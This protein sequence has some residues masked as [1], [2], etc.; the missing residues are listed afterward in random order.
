VT[1]YAL[2]VDLG[3]TFSAAA[4]GRGAT[5]EPLSLGTEA[6][7]V[8]SVVLIRD[9]GEILV[10]D[11]AERRSGLEPINTAR[12]FKRRLGDPV[13]LV[14]GGVTHSVES[15]MAHV[16]RWIVERATEREGE[17]PA[18]VVLTH[19]ANYFGYKIGALREV[20]R[21]AGLDADHVVLL[22][23]PEAA[24]ISY[25]REQRVESGEV[26]AVYDFGG[27]TFDAALVRRTDDH[28]E[29]LGVP[30]GM[31][32]LGGIDFD[33]AVMAH[34]DDALGGQVSAANPDDPQTWAGLARLRVECR[35]AKEALS[36]DTDTVVPVALP[37]LQMDVALTRHDLEAMVRPRIS[38]TTHALTRVV[39]SAGIGMD[40][41]TR[42]LLVG[43][44]SRMPIVAESV[45]RS[46]GRPV[47][48][49]AHPK[50][51]IAVG[52]ALAGAASLAPA[53]GSDAPVWHPPAPATHSTEFRAHPTSNGGGANRGRK[54][55]LIIAAVGGAIG[56]AAVV[57][58]LVLRG[59]SSSDSTAPQAT[60]ESSAV[61]ASVTTSA[62]SGVTTVPSAAA[63]RGVDA[64]VTRV[65]FGTTPAG[66][67]IPGPPLE[68]GVAGIDALAV[69]AQGDVFVATPDGAVL[70]ISADTV[71]VVGQLDQADGAPGGI[72]VTSDGSV[73]VSTSAGVLAIG[74]GGS[75]L[76]VDA[77]AAGLGS[78]PGPLAIDGGGNLYISDNGTHRIVR[79][80]TDGTLSLVAGTG[81]AAASGPP[82]GDGQKAPTVALGNV[83]G[84][85]ID[86]TGN[87]FV[88]DDGVLAV[89][90]I[91]PDGTVSTLAGG[92][93]AP[94][95][96][97]AGGFVA[98]GTSAADVAFGSIDG[99]AVDGEGR[100]YVAD[101]TSGAIVRIDPDGRL[102]MVITRNAENGAVDGVPARE[103]S[104]DAVGSLVVDR[105]GAL[106]FE[107]GVALRRIDGL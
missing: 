82:T 68:A 11:A 12:E 23:E 3:T 106:S 95:G 67:G 28:F 48:L 55:G 64:V 9:N 31:E 94:L 91:A 61:P 72:A 18:V 78:T 99:I 98:D 13:P 58:A 20:A 102:A 41:V 24:A 105:F 75:T 73:L 88:A 30:E 100:V 1:A 87:I 69:D 15:L 101:A 107:D 59:G 35:R 29:L 77:A 50:L 39:A 80:Q 42:V 34:V 57:A 40:Q 83:T 53:D 14:I 22:T 86:A 21:L 17:A 54:R 89:R 27:G 79:R 45:M 103:S 33:Q 76:L 37:G 70:R 84:L 7:Q 32:R 47:G 97:G 43:G 66:S 26:V 51:A 2:G 81:V 46:T 5:A 85:A 60:T 96:D 8:P 62:T 93:A 6:A 25:A 38:E 52:A 10:G 71:E 90:K 74:A 44:T 36:T 92:G 63:G 65:A 56:V 4:I 49:D 104:V 16:L 19:P